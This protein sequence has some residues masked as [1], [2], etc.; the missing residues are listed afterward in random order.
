RVTHSQTDVFNINVHSKTSYD[1]RPISING[2]EFRLRFY[3]TSGTLQLAPNTE[4]QFLFSR[5]ACLPKN[6]IR[7]LYAVRRGYAGI[8]PSDLIST[9]GN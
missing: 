8:L 6:T 9:S 5:K 2:T 4:M 1:I 3:D 7:G